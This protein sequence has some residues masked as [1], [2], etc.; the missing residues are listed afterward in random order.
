[1]TK[2]GDSEKISRN[3]DLQSPIILKRAITNRPSLGKLA[4]G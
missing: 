3:G 4:R 2:E 1:M